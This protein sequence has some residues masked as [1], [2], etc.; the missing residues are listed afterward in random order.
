MAMA[1]AFCVVA[2]PCLAEVTAYAP[3][4]GGVNSVS[5]AVDVRASVRDRCGFASGGAPAG[6]I[7]QAEFDRTG[8]SRDFVIALNCTGASRIAVSSRNGGLTTDSSAPGYASVAPY[9]VEL[10]MVGDNGTTASGACEASTLGTAGG[11]TFAGAAS[12]SNGLR[13]AAASTK[14]NGSY[15]RVQADA[16]AGATPL[17]A[18]RYTDTL[19]VTVSVAP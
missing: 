15:L 6:A 14:A 19:T 11:C 7:D 12:S 4:Q 2:K 9:R 1:M 3:G 17:L 8:F 18:G 10:R 5:V 16:Y 13:L